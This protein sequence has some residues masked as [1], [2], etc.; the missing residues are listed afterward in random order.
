MPGWV[1]VDERHGRLYVL[2]W[3]SMGHGSLR[4]NGWVCSTDQQLPVGEFG[5]LIREALAQS[6]TGVPMVNFRIPSESPVT[7]LLALA[8]VKSYEGYSRSM[9]A[10][11]IDLDDTEPGYLIR[12]TRNHPRDGLIDLPDAQIR[13]PTSVTDPQLGDAV[14]RGVSLSVGRPASLWRGSATARSSDGAA[15]ATTTPVQISA[16][17]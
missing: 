5:A 17:E 11:F 13:L 16:D 15:D 3:S 9:R 6:R 12:P 1:E 10:C 8:G 4:G 14:R 7:P 2:S